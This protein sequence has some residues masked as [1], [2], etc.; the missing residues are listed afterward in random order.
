MKTTM[1][2]KD[3]RKADGFP[4]DIDRNST[5]VVQISDSLMP[6]VLYQSKSG[7]QEKYSL[8]YKLNQKYK[9]GIYIIYP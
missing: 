7:L 9:P 1:K 5:V 4:V 2:M 3:L 8:P 6:I